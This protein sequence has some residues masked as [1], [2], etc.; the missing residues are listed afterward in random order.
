MKQW[1]SATYEQW[2]TWTYESVTHRNNMELW[3][4]DNIRIW[5]YELCENRKIWKLNKMSVWN[6]K[7]T[8]TYEIA[9]VECKASHMQFNVQN[10]SLNE[11]ILNMRHW[12]LNMEYQPVNNQP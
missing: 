6:M 11:N 8:M 5:K 12:T 9:N 2:K 1:K 10:S 7:E 4:H 3:E